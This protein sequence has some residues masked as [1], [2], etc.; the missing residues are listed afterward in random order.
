MADLGARLADDLTMLA[1][2]W[3]IVRRDGVALGFTTHDRP[4]LIGGLRHDS[5]PGM[6]PSA[7]VRSDGID[8]DTMDVAGA[9]SAQ[10][11]TA[12]DLDAGR[13]DGAAVTL[14][15]V[16][17]RVPNAGTQELATGTL[18]NVEI[19][20][21]PDAGFTASLRGPTAAL[22]AT[23][24]ES[25]SPE[26]RAELGDKRCRVDVRG[27]RQRAVVLWAVGDRVSVAAGA[28]DSADYAEGRMRVMTGALAG[29]ER[30]II[31]VADEALVLDDA[32]SLPAGTMLELVQGCDKRFATCAGR[33]GNAENFRGEP[34]VPGGDVLTRFGGF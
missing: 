29:V 26:C 16:D 27:R 5:A 11:I 23:A 24:V 4:L 8:I 18:G 32:L 34:H 1:L 31:G 10:A 30:R 14:F 19:G 20:L 6:A 2:C 22:L 21:G 9:L 28:G 33:F 15:L 3:R 25:Y 13:Y 7:V 17:W 12:A